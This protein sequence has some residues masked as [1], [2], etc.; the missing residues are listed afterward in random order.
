MTI[1]EFA[2]RH[3]ATPRRLQ[4]EIDL[5]QAAD[6]AFTA[7]SIGPAAAESRA[8]ALDGQTVPTRAGPRRGRGRA[9]AQRRR[10]PAAVLALDRELEAGLRNC[11]G[12]RPDPSSG[13]GVSRRDALSRSPGPLVRVKRAGAGRRSG[14]L[15]YS[16]AAP[17]L[18]RAGLPAFVARLSAGVAAKVRDP[19]PRLVLVTSSRRRLPVGDLLA[20]HCM[21]AG[22]AGRAQRRSPAQRSQALARR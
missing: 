22:R 2:E 17:A 15:R 18:G 4:R 7:T 14:A 13:S 6:E 16:A 11:P 19:G 5:L 1:P 12:S 21:G 20:V 10:K 8:A 3:R 9:A